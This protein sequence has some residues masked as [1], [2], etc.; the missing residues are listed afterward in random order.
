[1]IQ[2]IKKK[3]TTVRLF[4]STYKRLNQLGHKGESYDDIINRVLDALEKL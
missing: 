2:D 3:D 1:M 4:R